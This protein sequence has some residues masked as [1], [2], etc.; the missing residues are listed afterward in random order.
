MT[1]R[2]KLALV[3]LIAFSIF[4]FVVIL[5]EDTRRQQ[6]TDAAIGSFCLVMTVVNFRKWRAADKNL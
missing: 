5:Y 3:L 1:G 4:F 6:V 2:H